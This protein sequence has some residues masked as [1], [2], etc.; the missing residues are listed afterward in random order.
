MPFD[1]EK[2]KKLV[3]YICWRCKD[4]PSRLGAVK[5]NKSLWAADFTAYVS[6]GAPITGARYVKRQFG[7]A[8]SAIVPVVAEL[9]A[10]GALLVRDVAYHGKL[11]KEYVAHGA[12]PPP[13]FM[14]PAEKDIADAAIDFVCDAHTAGSISE[15]THD[16]VWKA[17]AE[18]EEIP[19][20]TV[21]AKPGELLNEDFLWGFEQLEREPQP[22][23]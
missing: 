15:A 16:H 6:L 2:F 20:Y 13:D 3:Y 10:E 23:C 21:F 18:G 19:Y 1:R 7:P 17:A 9:S 12:P 4:D 11:K 5:L 22:P 8:P 14:S